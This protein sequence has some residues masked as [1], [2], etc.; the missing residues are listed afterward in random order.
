VLST[1]PDLVVGTLLTFF[2]A[3]ASEKGR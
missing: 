2:D 3:P 1:N